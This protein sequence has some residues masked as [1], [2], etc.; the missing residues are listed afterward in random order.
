MA[1]EIECER[2][3]E[4]AGERGHPHLTHSMTHLELLPD[5]YVTQ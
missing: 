4:T 2:E 5:G 1:K 3:R